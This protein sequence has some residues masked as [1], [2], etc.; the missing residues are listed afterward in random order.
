MGTD[1]GAGR[2][3]AARRSSIAALGK[4]AELGGLG[5]GEAGL[6]LDDDTGCEVRDDLDLDKEGENEGGGGGGG[7]GGGEEEEAAGPIRKKLHRQKSKVNLR[8]HDWKFSGNSVSELPIMGSASHSETISGN[9]GPKGKGRRA[10]WLVRQLTAGA[11]N[12][13]QDNEDAARDMELAAILAERDELD[14]QLALR[15]KERVGLELQLK[16]KAKELGKL[17]DNLNE[18]T[19]ELDDLVFALEAS[20]TE[21]KYLHDEINRLKRESRKSLS[22]ITDSDKDPRAFMKNEVMT[23]LSSYRQVVHRNETAAEE[24][25]SLR[26]QMLEQ[27][28]D[29]SKVVEMLATN[30]GYWLLGQSS[31]A[32]GLGADPLEQIMEAQQRAKEL[33]DDAIE[34]KASSGYGQPTKEQQAA[35]AVDKEMIDGSE[36]L[37]RK[38]QDTARGKSM[39]EVELLRRQ[40]AASN[41][42]KQLM[43]EQLVVSEQ[44][45]E[46]LSANLRN[47]TQTR[48]ELEEQLAAQQMLL[49]GALKVM[50][51]RDLSSIDEWLH[52]AKELNL[53]ES[54]EAQ[55]VQRLRSTL[56][57]DEG[58]VRKLSDITDAVDRS[59]SV[60]LDELNGLL[61]AA[62]GRSLQEKE[63]H[64]NVLARAG[65]VR[66]HLQ[67][68]RDAVAALELAVRSNDARL[69]QRA[70]GDALDKDIG[71]VPRNS[72][73]V[74]AALE[75]LS[76]LEQ[77]ARAEERLQ[78]AAQAKDR[79]T[80]EEAMAVGRA[81]GLT[82]H[83]SGP[84][85]TATMSL[86]R[87]AN[88]HNAQQALHRAL[89]WNE[90]LHAEGIDDSGLRQSQLML[91]DN[92]RK[93]NMASLEEL[94]RALEVASRAG[95]DFES[96][97]AAKRAHE[98]VVK[99]TSIQSALRGAIASQA[100]EL[101]AEAIDRAEMMLDLPCT[102]RPKSPLG[103]TTS[104]ASSADDFGGNKWEKIGNT[105]HHGRGSTFLLLEE[106]RMMHARL[107]ALE[108]AEALLEEA[109]AS[110]D[111]QQ[112]KHALCAADE[113]GV[114][115]NAHQLNSQGDDAGR[116]DNGSALLHTA[117]IL[118]ARMETEETAVAT[119]K[120]AI[121]KGDDA[122]ALR[123]ALSDATNVGLKV[124][125]I[126][127]A[128]TVLL[129]L[130]ALHRLREA[131]ESNDPRQLETAVH[132][133]RTLT[134]SAA[135]VKRRGSM[136]PH[137]DKVQADCAGRSFTAEQTEAAAVRNFGPVARQHYSFNSVAAAVF[138]ALD[139]PGSRSRRSLVMLEEDL[140]RAEKMMA[141]QK[142]RS[143]ARRKS[144][145]ALAGQLLSPE[146]VEEQFEQVTNSLADTAALLEELTG[147]KVV[148]ADVE[149]NLPKDL[150]RAF[151][152][153][154]FVESCN[155]RFDE[156]A[157]KGSDQEG[158]TPD[159]LFPVI[160]EMTQNVRARQFAGLFFAVVSDP[161]YTA[162][163]YGSHGSFVSPIYANTTTNPLRLSQCTAPLTPPNRTN[164]TNSGSMGNNMGAVRKIRRYL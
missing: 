11:E 1:T 144:S 48:L 64:R 127:A 26:Q 142:K 42:D 23:A 69:V 114:G 34:N 55:T 138:A 84:F 47:F 37:V 44:K 143:E 67:R 15:N 146:L 19:S 164:R 110:R 136:A 38:L 97:E 4:A 83:E 163:I 3:A 156:L 5:P 28:S 50:E 153:G 13:T 151:Q 129:E 120:R 119:L 35:L 9:P 117:R 56:V 16:S 76:H 95:I 141:S 71:D 126:A 99:Q 80:L 154:A 122:V 40:L 17:E 21:N 31:G 92:E 125:E 147:M 94:Q 58:L 137:D 158:L 149:K 111:L 33:R 105:M 27:Q 81:L 60:D 68:R 112:L 59:E 85:H 72:P 54:A 102:L 6:S 7:G 12:V 52:T 159:E 73:A 70:L 133:A 124:P 24:Q 157:A 45:A 121:E 75:S 63:T 39:Q 135:V 162:G 148:I 89:G 49:T 66:A 98:L 118:C 128:Q 32:E 139:S 30:M 22:N 88:E 2:A 106:A 46:D 43:E 74:T 96:N 113:V 91:N 78:K 25:K 103:S 123:E 101:L 65:A 150:L 41:R 29:P 20:N 160:L 62:A 152:T 132:N 53:A 86:A 10:S 140:G 131:A 100:Q 79:G 115:E 116:G 57:E 61:A 107:C 87:I 18:Q 77:V 130:G 14:M 145:I 161:V 93:G 51:G 108:S 36:G 8:E 104:R 82:T 134:E 155:E 109:V 90:A